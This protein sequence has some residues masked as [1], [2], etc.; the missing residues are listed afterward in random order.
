MR[1]PYRSLLHY[2]PTTGGEAQV[3]FG[4]MKATGIGQREQG[5]VALDFFTEIKA[6]YV[7]YTGVYSN[8]SDQV[9]VPLTLAAGKHYLNVQAWDTSGAVFKKVA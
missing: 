1:R 9:D 4:G 7:D 8:T 5:S 3:P 2:S 6:V